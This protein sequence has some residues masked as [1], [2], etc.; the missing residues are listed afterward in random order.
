MQ[1]PLVQNPKFSASHAGPDGLM[2][3]LG[4]IPKNC[5]SINDGL[6]RHERQLKSG[7]SYSVWLQRYSMPCAHKY[8][9][10]VLKM[11]L[12]GCKDRQKLFCATSQSVH[13][14]MMW[15]VIGH[16]RKRLHKIS[17]NLHPN[18]HH[19]NHLFLSL[20]LWCFSSLW[21]TTH[22]FLM[23]PH[24]IIDC[25]APGRDW[26]NVKGWGQESSHTQ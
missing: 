20:L 7:V 15:C 6:W 23:Q 14:W 4:R 9:C 21:S 16:T 19:L 25:L 8:G 1:K 18:L 24:L 11:A 3:R 26:C 2:M 12:L 22:S 5:K 10:S 17:W 13:T